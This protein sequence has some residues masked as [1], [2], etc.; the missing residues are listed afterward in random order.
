[1]K[2]LVVIPLSIF[3]FACHTMKKSSE[4]NA[5]NSDFYTVLYQSNYQGRDSEENVVLQNQEDL[6]TLFK[7]VGNDEIPQVDFSK[8]QV[9]ALFLGTRNT[10]GYSIFIDRVEVDGAKLIVYKKE[11]L[12]KE[13]KVTTALTNPFIIAEIH[14]K[15]EIVFR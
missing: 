7:S 5:L 11:G 1:M 13:G 8:N 14:S 12:P 10:G 15:K 9:V 6:N 3:L 4:N 2:K